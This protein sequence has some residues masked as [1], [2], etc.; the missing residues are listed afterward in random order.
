MMDDKQSLANQLA[1]CI[2]TKNYLNEMTA[3]I[4][5][6]EGK[7]DGFVATL[8]FAAYFSEFLPEIQNMRAELHEIADDFVKHIE[9]EHLAYIEQ[10]S[11][12]IRT[13]LNDVLKN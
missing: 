11:K 7:Y 5:D 2:T 10:Q 6:V 13:I 4:R 9:T 8:E 3:Q 1:W 12:H